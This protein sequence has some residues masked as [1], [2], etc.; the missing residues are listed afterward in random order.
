MPCFADNVNCRHN[1]DWAS[2]YLVRLL[3]VIF[4]GLADSAVSKVRKIRA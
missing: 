3:I 1:E 2:G 4:F